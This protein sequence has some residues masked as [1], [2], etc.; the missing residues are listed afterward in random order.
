MDYS[1]IREVKN[2]KGRDRDWKQHD[3]E[4]KDTGEY[5]YDSQEDSYYTQNLSRYSRYD[6]HRY[7]MTGATRVQER[8]RGGISRYAGVNSSAYSRYEVAPR[9]IRGRGRGSYAVEQ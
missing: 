1:A 3:E 9:A 2:V 7:G 5:Q 8:G 6:E 4:V